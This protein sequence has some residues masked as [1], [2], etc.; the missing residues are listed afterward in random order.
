MKIL[1]VAPPFKKI[2]PNVLETY[3]PLGILCLSSFLKSKGIQVKM[4]DLTALS[5]PYKKL[6]EEITCYKPKVV[7]IGSIIASYTG[8]IKSAELVKKTNKNIKVV[9]GGIYSTFNDEFILKNHPDIDFIV[10]GEGE[11]TLYQLLISI[12]DHHLLPKIAGLSYIRNGKLIKTRDQSL[13]KDLSKLPLPDYDSLKT[14]PI[15]QK[16]N[17]F[18]VVSSR[19]CV[20]NCTFCSTSNYWKH[21]WRARSAESL[22]DELDILVNKYN[23][24]DI[25]M[26]DDLFIVD[27]ERVKSIC[28]GIL[29]R[30]LVFN[31]RCSIRANFFTVKMA[32]LL[33]RA[34][35]DSVFLGVESGDRSILQKI[36][37]RQTNTQA[38]KASEICKHTG[39]KLVASYIVGFP[40]ETEKNINNTIKLAKEINADQSI[41]F[42]FHPDIGSPIYKE[43]NSLR[44]KVIDENPDNCID[45]GESHI[46]TQFL[47]KSALENLYVRAILSTNR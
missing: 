46:E 11:I 32:K 1:L 9:V 34:G 28:N 17:K 41:W 10:R 5:N 30:K 40:W 31:W 23:A 25:L 13:I 18:L 6:A 26:G 39:L 19:G 8:T 42:L 45:V 27:P 4:L 29:N 36:N 12:N 47:S 35:C 7:G 14:M 37:K 16:K 43:L 3:P 2:N 33:K 44:I 21:C 15:Y 24:K 20:F 38:K 22:L